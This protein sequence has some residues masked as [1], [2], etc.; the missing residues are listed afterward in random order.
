M[1]NNTYNFKKKQ[2]VLG[3]LKMIISI[4]KVFDAGM[5]IISIALSV[6]FNIFLNNQYF[7]KSETWTN[8]LKFERLFTNIIY[9]FIFVIS[10]FIILF[11]L[12]WIVRGITYGCAK[13]KSFLKMRYLPLSNE[14]IKETLGENAQYFD[15]AAFIQNFLSVKLFYRNSS[16]ISTFTFLNGWSKRY[17]IIKIPSELLEQIAESAVSYFNCTK[18]EFEF[19][20]KDKFKDSYL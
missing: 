3:L 19:A 18:E 8:T 10:F 2:S 7:K 6:L 1:K 14:E 5:I 12:S 15:Y 11:A 16:V 17:C 13:I 20:Y 4:Y 9:S